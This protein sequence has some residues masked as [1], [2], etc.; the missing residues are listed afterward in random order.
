MPNIGAALNKFIKYLDE[1]PDE[2]DFDA[3]ASKKS[4]TEEKDKKSQGFLISSAKSS[5]TLHT[6]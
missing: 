1:M 4:K 5:E 6:R 3:P 2:V